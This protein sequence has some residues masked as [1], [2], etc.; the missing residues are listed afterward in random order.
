[1]K[2]IEQ[3]HKERAAAAHGR[4]KALY[5]ELDKLLRNDLVLI[6]H[7]HNQG[8]K[9]HACAIAYRAVLRSTGDPELAWEAA[10]EQQL[11]SMRRVQREHEERYH[12]MR[13]D[14]YHFTVNHLRVLESAADRAE[15]IEKLA[16][17]VN[18]WRP[19]PAAAA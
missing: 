18:P 2:T 17:A 6:K 3:Q 4:N 13:S 12:N 11:A 5:G 9:D 16:N 1:M 8:L 7:L 19:D 14:V 15:D 10:R